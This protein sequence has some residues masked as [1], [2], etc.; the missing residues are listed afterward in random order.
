MTLLQVRAAL[1]IGQEQAAALCKGIKR[2]P[3]PKP[4]TSSGGVTVLPYIEPRKRITARPVGRRDIIARGGD[5]YLQ[6]T[7]SGC[8]LR[9]F[10]DE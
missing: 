5:L 9:G 1:H 2:G 8:Y 3:K 7:E 10:A 4:V 6:F